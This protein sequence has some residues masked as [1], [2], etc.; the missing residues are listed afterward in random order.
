MTV[1]VVGASGVVGRQLVP[2]LVAAGHPVVATY[3]SHPPATLPDGAV[4]RQL[5]L[6]DAS[7]TSR[8]VAAV[9]PEAIVHLATALSGLGT[10]CAGSMPHSR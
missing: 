7:A 9:E 4:A 5:D 8:L 10:T 2:Q 3:R 1:L 6:L